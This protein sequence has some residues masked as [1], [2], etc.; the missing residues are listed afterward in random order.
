MPLPS[1]PTKRAD[2]LSPAAFEGTP[3]AGRQSR[4]APA[5]ELP[6]QSP[7]PVERAA[8]GRATPT[9][10]ASLLSKDVGQQV[11]VQVE[12]IKRAPVAPAAVAAVT[13][14][15]ASTGV[16]AVWASAGDAATRAAR[17]TKRMNASLSGVDGQFRHGGHGG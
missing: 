15:P 17:I 10:Q 4:R 7:A 14:P 6:V 11:A 16:G 9:R 12:T 13:P 1:A 2:R 8:A 5:E 3:K